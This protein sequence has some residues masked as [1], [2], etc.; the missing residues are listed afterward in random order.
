MRDDMALRVASRLREAISLLSRRRRH[1]AL[2]HGSMQS[3]DS[4]T[5]DIGETLYVTRPDDF[6]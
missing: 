1:R 2:R 3:A 4:W 6:R 5:M